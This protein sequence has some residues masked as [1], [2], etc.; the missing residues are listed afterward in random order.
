ME[1]F[2]LTSQVGADGKLKLEVSTHLSDQPVEV[3]VVI[4]P[5]APMVAAYP[6]DYFA[7]LDR[8]AADDLVER[9]DQG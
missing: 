3:L 2:K 9:P 8:I 7:R 1:T 4:Q 6:P 5:A